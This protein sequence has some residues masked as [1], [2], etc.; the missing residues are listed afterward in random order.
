MKMKAALASAE[1]LSKRMLLELV[2][3]KYVSGWDDPRMPTISGLR[4]RGF[5]PE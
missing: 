5:T 4:R 1:K 3:K 2:E